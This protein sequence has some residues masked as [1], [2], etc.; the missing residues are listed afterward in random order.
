MLDMEENGGG[1]GEGELRGEEEGGGKGAAGGD[2]EK[3]EGKC[4]RGEEEKSSDYASSTLHEKLSIESE[5]FEWKG[6]KQVL[7]EACRT[8]QEMVELDERGEKGKSAELVER[9]PIEGREEEGAEQGGGGQG[10][11]RAEDCSGTGN[12]GVNPY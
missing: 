12:K 3:K 6:A 10:D 5:S 9:G 8:N 11:R 2:E 7:E 1:G 4:E